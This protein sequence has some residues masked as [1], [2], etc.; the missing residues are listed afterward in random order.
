M[1]KETKKSPRGENIED[2][3]GGW[4]GLKA[5]SLDVKEALSA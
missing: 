5:N 2:Q 4:G 1:T 3:R